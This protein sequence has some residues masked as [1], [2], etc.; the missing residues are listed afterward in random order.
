MI[1]DKDI[2]QTISRKL[3]GEFCVLGGTFTVDQFNQ[4]EINCS[5]MTVECPEC[6]YWSPAQSRCTRYAH[7]RYLGLTADN[8][9]PE[10]LI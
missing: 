9:Y 6:P 3:L 7:L 8:S 2:A 1:T 4:V 5:H 10:F